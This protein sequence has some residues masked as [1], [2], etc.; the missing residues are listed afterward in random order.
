MKAIIEKKQKFY[1]QDEDGI[2]YDNEVKEIKVCGCD[3]EHQV[4]LI[5]TFAF[6]GAEYWCPYCGYTC[7]MMGAGEDV[8]ITKEL[9]D[10]KDK[11]VELS[12]D[13]LDAKSTTVCSSLLFEGKRISPDEL[14]VKE[15]E[16]VLKIIADWKYDV[17]L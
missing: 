14:P 3:D 15:K 5:W 2:N 9:V 4:P 11:Y 16:R 17:K 13:Y 7:G 6:D 12:K 1:R 8:P 10:R